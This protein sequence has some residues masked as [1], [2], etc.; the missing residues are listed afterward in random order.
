MENYRIFKK[1]NKVVVFDTIDCRW[2]RMTKEYFSKNKDKL[3]SEYVDKEKKKNSKIKTVYLSLTRKCNMS[4]EFCSSKSGPNV[5][6]TGELTYEEIKNRLIPVLQKI[7]PRSLILSG[8]EPL[9][10]PDIL[11]IIDVFYE[12]LPTVNLVLQTNG[13]LLNKE[14][15]DTIRTRISY[16]EVSIEDIFYN[17][18]LRQKLCE[19]IDLIKQV[20]ISMQFSYVISRDNVKYVQEVLQLVNKYKASILFRF[21]SPIGNAINERVQFMYAEDIKKFYLDLIDYVIEKKYTE[22]EILNVVLPPLQIT[23]SCG[24]YGKMVYMNPTGGFSACSGLDFS[25]YMLGNIHNDFADIFEKKLDD[26]LNKNSVKDKLLVDRMEHCADCD[27]K[28]FCCGVCAAKTYNTDNEDILFADCQIKKVIVYFWLFDFNRKVG[29][30]D[31]LKI[32]RERIVNE[33][34]K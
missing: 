5:D 31:N 12:K 25:P 14:M 1:D 10:R 26:V 20:G 2:D 29:I 22:E 23:D 13:L 34:D 19:T 15:L 9:I 16:I 4:C 11:D 3:L 30:I 27:I 8:G 32:L 17:E 24:A 33:Y 21:V 28:Y 6:T 7:S 18:S